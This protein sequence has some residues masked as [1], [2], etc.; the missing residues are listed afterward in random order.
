MIRN[1]YNCL[2]HP[3]LNTKWK[4]G[5]QNKTKQAKSLDVSSFPEDGRESIQKFDIN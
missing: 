5:I 3:V 2:P 1:Q 4:D